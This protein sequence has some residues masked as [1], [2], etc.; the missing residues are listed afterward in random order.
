MKKT[1]ERITSTAILS[2][3]FMLSATS[4]WAAAPV[5][6]VV[7]DGAAGAEYNFSNR[8]KT[9]GGVTY[10]IDNIGEGT[11]NTSVNICATDSSYIQV[12]NQDYGVAAPVIKA[13]G[14][15]SETAFGTTG[16]STVIVKCEFIS[17]ANTSDPNRAVL[18]FLSQTAQ[19][20]GYLHLG[21]M[22]YKGYEGAVYSIKNGSAY[23]SGSLGA[24]AFNAGKRTLALSYK[25]DTALKCYG[26]GVSKYTWNTP[27]SSFTAPGGICIGGVDYTA[28][29][30][31]FYAMKCMKIYAIAIFDSE[32]TKEQIA[33]YAF[34]SSSY[35]RFD[36]ASHMFTWTTAANGSSSIDM[37]GGSSRFKLFDKSL[38]ADTSEYT[39]NLKYAEYN[40]SSVESNWE[41]FW[42]SFCYVQ[43]I[44]RN[45]NGVWVNRSPNYS[46]PGAVLRLVSGCHT[47]IGGTFAPFTLGGLL[48][49]DGAEGYSF[50]Q[51]GSGRNT[52]LGDPR[53]AD[54]VP[55]W[56]VANESVAFNRTGWMYLTGTINFDIEENCTV[57]LNNPASDGDDSYA[58][59]LYRSLEYK[60]ENPV[61]GGKLIMRG[62]GNISVRT[63]TASGAK[64]DYSNLT[65]SRMATPGT[66]S[67]IQGNLV[68]DGNT[69]FVFPAGMAKNT[70]YALCSGTL[71]NN[72]ASSRKATI[73]VGD[74]TFD[75]ILTFDTSDATVSYVPI[76][77]A[78]VD[79]DST[80][81]DLD[82]VP[83]LDAAEIAGSKF[84]I[85]GSGKVTG[86]SAVPASIELD[87][88]VTLDVTAIAG[89]STTFSGSGTLLYTSNYPDAVPAGCSYEYVGSD[90]EA[91]PAAKNGVTVNGVLKT[92]GHLSLTTFSLVSAGTLEV[93]DGKTTVS[94]SAKGLA[95]TVIVRDDATLVT[96]TD[97]MPNYDGT[98]V[99][100]IYGTLDTGSNGRWCLYANN[101][102]N[103]YAG[104]TVK[105]TPANGAIHICRKAGLNI[106]AHP[107]DKTKTEVDFQ[108]KLKYNRYNYD[109]DGGSIITV[110]EGV[111]LVFSGVVTSHDNNGGYLRKQGPGKIKFAPEA[112]VSSLGVY[113]NIEEGA[114]DL[115]GVTLAGGSSGYVSVA[116]GASLE[117]S[118]NS[119]I[120]LPLTLADGATLK[121]DG[122]ASLTVSQA[123]TL[124]TG[125]SESVTLDLNDASLPTG[126]TSSI[127]L[128]AS[129]TLNLDV[130]R[131]KF[132]GASSDYYLSQDATSGAVSIK[133]HAAKGSDGVYRDNMMDAFGEILDDHDLV[134]TV[135]DGTGASNATLVKS[136]NIAW[137]SENNQF[138]Y[139]YAKIGN[140]P[141]I[142]LTAAIEAS[143]IG[144]T[145]TLI[146]NTTEKVAIKNGTTLALDGFTVGSV[147]AESGYVLVPDDAENPTS[148]STVEAKVSAEIGG[149]I[150]YFETL[151]NALAAADGAGTITLIADCSENANLAAG[152]TLVLGGHSYTGELSGSGTVVLSNL[153]T[154]NLASSWTGTVW[155]KNQSGIQIIPAN[156]GNA[157]SVIRFTGI[158]GW[159]AN[160]TTCSPAFEFEDEG[161]TK[162]LTMYYTSAPSTTLTFSEFRGTGTFVTAGN[163]GGYTR[164][165]FK[166]LKWSDFTGSLDIDRGRV[167]FGEDT[168][169]TDDWRYIYV[170]ANETATVA[171]GKIWKAYDGFRVNGTL[172]CNGGKIYGTGASETLKLGGSGLIVNTFE[173][174]DAQCFNAGAITVSGSL[175]VKMVG[176][177]SNFGTWTLT[178]TASLGFDPGTDDEIYLNSTIVAAPKETT[179]HIYGNGTKP[180]VDNDQDGTKDAVI[181]VH[182]G[183]KFQVSTSAADYDRLKW[184][185]RNN[186]GGITVDAGGKIVFKSRET[187]TRNTTL[188]GG[189]FTLDGIQS[190]RSI[191]INDNIDVNVTENSIIEATGA[192]HWI[193][194]R[195]GTPTFT[196]D[197]NKT[198]TVNAGFKYWFANNMTKA[199][200]GTMVVNG[201]VDGSGNHE[202]FSQPKGVTI[203]AGTYELNAV[204]TSNNQTGDNAN[205]YTVAAGAKLKIGATGQANMTTLNLVDGS[206]LEFGAG[207]ATLINANTVTFASGEVAVSL[208][209]GVTPANGTK[210]IGWTTAPAGDFKLS[211]SALAYALDKRSD[212]LYLV[213]AAAQ[214]GDTYYPTVAAAFESGKTEGSTV[215]LLQNVTL[216]DW[217]PVGTAAAP[218]CG[219]INGNGKTITLETPANCTTDFSL[220]GVVKGNITIQD[221]TV[222]ASISSTGKMVA[223]LVASCG[224]KAAVTCN[225]TV[226]RVK[227]T[228][229]I[230]GGEKV[231]GIVA[232]TPYSSTTG[233]TT[234]IDCT[235]TASVVATS[236]ASGDLQ[237]A[238]G[239]VSSAGGSASANKLTFTRCV[240]SGDVTADNGWA[241][242]FCASLNQ[243]DDAAISTKSRFDLTDCTNG[244]TI[245]GGASGDGYLVYCERPGSNINTFPSDGGKPVPTHPL[246]WTASR[247]SNSY[248]NN[249]TSGGGYDSNAKKSVYTGIKT[250]FATHFGSNQYAPDTLTIEWF[251]AG[252]AD[253][254]IPSTYACYIEINGSKLA[255]DSLIGAELCCLNTAQGHTINLLK[256]SSEDVSQFLSQKYGSNSSYYTSWRSTG[257]VVTLEL[258][259]FAYA[260]SNFKAGN[261]FVFK[262]NRVGTTFTVY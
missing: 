167:I 256:D 127:L 240:N 71:T 39:G 21:V 107:T 153:P 235:N 219:S 158:T 27:D 109:L 199:G 179:I 181:H 196:V 164:T 108:G 1:I 163:D 130:G 137:N 18:G 177:W 157:N 46:V 252:T 91:S 260:G 214:V 61:S 247:L 88:G 6:V 97:A 37:G 176:G 22:K 237:R 128:T 156:Y 116:N 169:S 193:Y 168:I 59:V 83:A 191:D 55:T 23:G 261:V 160:E 74:D 186:V 77:S 94:G 207:N 54:G 239:F 87:S 17:G 255:F 205:F 225:L 28:N 243:F 254:A 78:V 85:S 72:G 60:G 70:K 145:I 29:A 201:Y 262:V 212:G 79:G 62:L 119:T 151:A 220:L 15:G 233:T 161:D 64:L 194:L 63:L 192:S 93:L 175:Q 170:S 221:L 49:E 224:N 42:T 126:T 38:G 236:T 98:T 141:Y 110:D 218:F 45:E 178:D 13:S 35:Q 68:I 32:L 166:V 188:A 155:L 147:S 208:S 198:L 86:L 31:R 67:Y 185:S 135:L 140:E 234:F 40:S 251:P 52:I 197:A 209:E 203:N 152:V 143:T 102:V 20:Y 154:L 41:L 200:A 3:A 259:G 171:A 173:G 217:T 172:N 230:S 24:N 92:S 58:P 4:A 57:N 174:G 245:D 14:T 25:Y 238:G 249:I 123:V 211:G 7:W 89:E 101:T 206:L 56:F 106:K 11:D 229:S 226:E 183:G 95:G 184:D 134:I 244:G 210:L 90:A 257:L 253:S 111:A 96:A 129:A 26:D 47:A 80:F 250:K 202:S 121:I 223:A 9:V 84:V 76:Y 139:G 136:A 8:S 75:A 138:L 149:N 16:G 114:V 118:G 10:Y 150:R 162:A 30:N 231:A 105:G 242:A 113:L 117:V 248:Y 51:T 112:T 82:W 190:D 182:D 33:N 44:S 12:A 103:L 43:Y 48:V 241:A 81:A 73:S 144:D 100:H 246:T 216:T 120:S 146:R 50:T 53:D 19:E 148:Y 115:G 258:N 125:E 124:P 227:V 215:K 165:N 180:V 232:Q 132:E 66:D 65:A 2:V 69:S 133:L 213:N 195:S 122:S 99:A 204:Q 34:P 36:Y 228:G 159:I 142:S 222:N 104:A 187:Y 189:T 131:F 5:P